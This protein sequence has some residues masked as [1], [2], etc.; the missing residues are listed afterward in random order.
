MKKLCVYLD[1]CCFNRSYDDQEQQKIL[2]E[3]EAKLKIQQNIMEE[4]IELIWSYMLDL[5]NNDNP[6]EIIRS[7]IFEWKSL[8]VCD[9][10]ESEQ[11]LVKAEEIVNYGIDSKDAVH[12]A[13]AI[14]GKADLFFTTDNDIIKRGKD[15]K[16][17]K[18]LNPVQFFI[19]SE[20]MEEK[21]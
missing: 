8:C 5:E 10:I 21:I 9:I 18:I 2:L 7:A 12:I 20:Y 15:I 11:L 4:G 1:N 17:I 3:T 14:A 19:E 13:C 16:E 6:N